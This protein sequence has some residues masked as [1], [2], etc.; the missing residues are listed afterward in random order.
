MDWISISKRH[1]S[2]NE[3]DESV[4]GLI[5]VVNVGVSDQC[6]NPIHLKGDLFTNRDYSGKH[7][8]LKGCIVNRNCGVT[9][10]AQP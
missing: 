2:L 1:L 7:F 4:D 8:L 10:H 6:V 9:E 5:V 3:F